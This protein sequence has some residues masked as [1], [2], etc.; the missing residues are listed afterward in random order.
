MPGG[1]APRTWADLDNP[2]STHRIT[3]GATATHE[4]AVYWQENVL[5]LEK[6]A[7]NNEV[8]IVV[9][10]TSFSNFAEDQPTKYAAG[11]RWKMKPGDVSE[12]DCARRETD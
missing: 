1:S 10:G 8:W 12:K 5:P 4:E 3:L 2:E 6:E 11:Y 7:G 9:P